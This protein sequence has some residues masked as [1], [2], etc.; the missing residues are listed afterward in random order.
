MT[1][2]NLQN[3]FEKQ[4]PQ[5]PQPMMKTDEK[6]LMLLGLSITDPKTHELVGEFCPWDWMKK[7]M[8]LPNMTEKKFVK[9][10]E[11]QDPSLKKKI[12]GRGLEYTE[13]WVD[14]DGN[15]YCFPL[16][17]LDYNKMRLDIFNRQHPK[18]E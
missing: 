18:N 16:D 1:K 9:Q 8:A 17:S 5:L 3:E 6:T 11:K 15:N 13:H 7:M 10:A 4:L 2:M 14:K 12:R